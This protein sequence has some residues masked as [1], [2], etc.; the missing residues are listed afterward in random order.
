MGVVLDHMDEG[1][2]LTLYDKLSRAFKAAGLTGQALDQAI[3]D[4]LTP[5]LVT[6][7]ADRKAKADRLAKFKVVE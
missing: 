1:E 4:A 6:I 5:T 7:E 3:S 2:L